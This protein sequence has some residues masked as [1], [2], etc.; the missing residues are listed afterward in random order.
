MSKRL[1]LIILAV[2]ALSA[3]GGRPS[4]VLDPSQADTVGPIW[5]F[6][7]HTRDVNSIALSSDG[8]YL[9]TGSN[10]E[11]AKLWDL[12]SG[13]EIRTFQ[14]HTQGVESVALLS[15]GRYLVT[16]SNDGTAK[17]WDLSSGQEIRT[18]QGHTAGVM[19]V[20]L[21]SDGRYLVTGSN[22]E[23]AKLWDLSS[24]R[25]IRAFQGHTAYLESVALSSDGRYLVTGSGD[26]T[27]KLWD[28]SSGR[29]IRT[30]AG[31]A[32]YTVA[33]VALS[34]DGRYLVTGSWDS[35]A[36]LWD[37]SSGREIRTF[38]GHTQ[39]VDSVALSSGGRYLLTG[40]DDGTAKLWDLSSGREAGTFQGHTGPVW[41]VALSSDGRH[42]VT[43]SGDSTAKLWGPESPVVAPGPRQRARQDTGNRVALVVGNSSYQGVPLRNSV[44]DARDM[45]TAL[46]HLGFEVITTLDANQRQMEEAINGFAAKARQS[47]AALFYFSGHGVQASGEN[48]LIP[49][50]ADI[51]SESD[52]R[53]EAVHAGRVLGKMEEAGG[54]INIV[55]L[56]ACRDNPFKGFRSPS[57]GFAMMNAPRG[58]F[59][60][61]ATEPNSVARDGDGDNSPYTKH[62]LAAM[63]I[64][65]LTIEEVFRKV[66]GNVED[67]TGGQQTPWIGSSLRD[68]FYFSP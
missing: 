52:V 66:V 53:Y 41:S 28:L 37:L 19:S 61:Y 11:T 13:Q 1:G 55:I 22:D 6:E 29:E 9:V 32:G 35:T 42:L 43:G 27:A 12:S 4:Y 38:R 59:I 64:R 49:V 26:G 51:A 15:D 36:K 39:D 25:E 21:S 45:A 16:G 10:D 5:T 48:Y 65:G 3:C 17:L 60:A 62:L 58:S 7:G 57:K 46:G 18:F 31:D 14:G 44:N 24:G 23:T 8:R 20:A 50:Q 2:V 67:E 40:S 56:D 33:S 54:Q 47:D 30:F 63:A 34:S 68:A